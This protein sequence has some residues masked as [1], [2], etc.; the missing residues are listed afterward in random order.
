MNVRLSKW[1]GVLGVLWAISFATS[2]REDP[3]TWGVNNVGWLGLLAVW[4]YAM[5]LPHELCHAG[6]A[7]LLGLRV[8][9][10][11]VG[12]PPFRWQPRWLGI[13]W[14]L[15]PLPVAG[16]VAASFR[17]DGELP[18]LWRLRLALLIAAGPA[19]HGVALV[20]LTWL[21]QQA[22]PPLGTVAVDAGWWANLT[23]LV[24][25]LNPFAGRGGKLA[26][27]GAQLLGLVRRSVEVEALWRT[28]GLRHQAVQAVEDGD[29]ERA[30]ALL[31]AIKVR[32]PGLTLTYAAI[33]GT[34]GR[35]DDALAQFD[36]VLDDRSAPTRFRLL[37]AN[38]TAW[39]LAMLDRDLAR[40]DALSSETSDALPG[41]L[42]IQ[43]TRGAVLARLG[44]LDEARPLLEAATAGTRAPA[45]QAS[46]LAFK[47]LIE[48]DPA[49]AAKQVARA[50][51]LDPD[52]LALGLVWPEV[53]EPTAG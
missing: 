8:D 3:L 43:S 18:F 34:V 11:A 14:K 30:L 53:T 23:L 13:R 51:A 41:Q 5:V 4:A 27:D 19:V 21:G 7:K 38:D 37:A 1:W 50:R 32:D 16:H 6:A 46:S 12:R 20:G 15:S 31:G 9:W 48:G 52:N 49:V 26:S 39:Y 33:L 42:A 44:R 17:S 47:A 10:I 25:N 36:R 22:L 24:L 45:D 40:A 2:G 29:P 28:A 35:L